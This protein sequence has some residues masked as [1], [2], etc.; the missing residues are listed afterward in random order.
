MTDCVTYDM[1]ADYVRFSIE[2]AHEYVNLGKTNK[3]AN[4]Y[5][6]TWNAM[7]SLD[8]S[9][10][11]RVLFLLRYSESLIAMGSVLKG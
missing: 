7:S 8:V 6:H 9:N 2:L 4:I 1:S 5:N 3:A 11:T 10:E